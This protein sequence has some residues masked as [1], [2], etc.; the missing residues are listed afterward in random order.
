MFTHTIGAVLAGGSSS[1]MGHDK[2]GLE[3]LGVPFI[4]HAIATLSLA[5]DEVVVCGGSYSGPA[6]TLA[7]AVG[8]AGP[9]GGILSALEWADGRPVFVCAVDMPLITVDLVTRLVDPPVEVRQARVAV[10]AETGDVQPLC[11]TYGPGVDASIRRRSAGG[12]SSVF[13]L[14]SAL[15]VAYVSADAH[16]LTNVNTPSDLAALEP[17]GLV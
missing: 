1:R 5:V 12:D 9:L 7:D 6:T 8:V 14:L 3:Y 13:G 10:D 4:D 17:R 15:D 16:T 2:T 11:G